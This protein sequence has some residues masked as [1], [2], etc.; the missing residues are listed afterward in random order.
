MAKSRF[1]AVFIALALISAAGQAVAADY[2]SGLVFNDS[3]K[4]GIYDNGE[5]GIEG[6]LVSNGRINV[7]TD[8][9]GRYTIPVS[10]DTIIFVVKPRN[11]KTL[12][13]ENNV[14]RFYYIHKPKGSPP[15]LS[16]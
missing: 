15:L 3:N 13:D 10:D 9:S 14:P 1:T 12:V 16:K 8:S 5:A 11:W 6:V 7:R 4:N 2:A